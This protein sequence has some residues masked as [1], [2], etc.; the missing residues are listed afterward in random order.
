MAFGQVRANANNR[1][2]TTA[3]E[4]S[5]GDCIPV[6]DK[7]IDDGSGGNPSF[8]SPT[9]MPGRAV[10]VPDSNFESVSYFISSGHDY[11]SILRLGI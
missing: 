6:I 8:Q 7:A 4:S 1:S 2:L 11:I 9:L 10:C 5:G 3:L